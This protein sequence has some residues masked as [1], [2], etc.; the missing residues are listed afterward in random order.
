[1]LKD[2]SHAEIAMDTIQDTATRT[3][4]LEQ[5]AETLLD[6]MTIAES[7]NLQAISHALTEII[8][9]GGMH[10]LLSHQLRDMLGSP[11]KSPAVNQMP[12][13]SSNARTS[14]TDMPEPA[15][16][17]SKEEPD[18]RTL[19]DMPNSAESETDT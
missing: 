11:I 3:N 7:T 14:P 19:M 13:V 10:Q 6:V 15:G 5:D 9:D 8:Q 4:K 16:L 1:M 17:T 2:G 18:A 12:R